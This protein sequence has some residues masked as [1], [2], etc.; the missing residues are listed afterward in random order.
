MVLA[1]LYWTNEMSNYDPNAVKWYF[2]E[3]KRPMDFKR[4]S[5]TDGDNKLTEVDRV[6]MS[7]AEVQR[8][9]QLAMDEVKRCLHNALEK[10]RS[11]KLEKQVNGDIFLAS[12]SLG[13]L[14]WSSSSENRQ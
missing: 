6:E 2:E 8:G 14:C 11:S 9:L 10:Q 3:M 13:Y 4:F 1:L 12:I 7:D 5:Y